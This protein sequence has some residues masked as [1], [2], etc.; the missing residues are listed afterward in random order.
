[1][2]MYYAVIEPA[3]MKLVEHKKRHSP[4][5][6]LRNGECRVNKLSYLALVDDILALPAIKKPTA[7]NPCKVAII[8]CMDVEVSVN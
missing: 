2:F 7:I 8:Q 4:F 6:V 1:M 5:T 3:H